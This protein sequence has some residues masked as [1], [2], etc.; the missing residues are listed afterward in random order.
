M[1]IRIVKRYQ[2]NIPYPVINPARRKA[3]ILESKVWGFPEP[4]GSRTQ[5][6]M[7]ELILNACVAANVKYVGKVN[8]IHP[9]NT[10]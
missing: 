6:T 4:L 2:L 5:F 8:T 7:Q 10:P 9:F 1:P 3:S